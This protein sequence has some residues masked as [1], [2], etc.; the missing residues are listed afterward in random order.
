MSSNKPAVWWM[1]TIPFDKYEP[2][3]IEAIQYMKGQVEVGESG[4][5][6]Y[7]M[8]VCLK[9]K[10]RLTGIKKLFCK[11]A[12]LEP[13]RSAAAL[14]YVWKEETK[15]AESEFEFGKKPIN[16]NAAVDWEDVW[17]YAVNGE[18]MSIPAD[19]RVRCYSQLK[20]IEK[21]NMKPEVIERKCFVLVGNTDAGKSHR[22]WHAA[23]IDNAYC[24]DPNTK[25]W[26][27]Y[28]GQDS[29]VI[30]EFRG[31]ID[32]SHMLRW[33]DKWP[34]C[35]ENKGGGTVLKARRIFITSNLTPT[36]WYPNLDEATTAALLRR[37]KIYAVSNKSEVI[38]LE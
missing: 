33:L 34:V 6:H 5:K 20:R 21:D 35:V 36:Q 7:Q 25:F 2:Q 38:N 10:Q 19:I 3:L 17:K 32:I 8:V 13:T 4:Y 26:D 11:E 24:K 15:V 1:C 28:H 27:G 14:E 22:A 12:H 16:R 31:R 37:L 30:E 23:G 9:K 18:T 29:V